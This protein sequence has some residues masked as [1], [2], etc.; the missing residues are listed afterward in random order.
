MII[1]Y[2]G[3]VGILHEYYPGVTVEK[4]KLS[5]KTGENYN[6]YIFLIINTAEK[7]YNVKNFK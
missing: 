1:K 3:C 6:L 5:K 2:D 4:Q 7:R